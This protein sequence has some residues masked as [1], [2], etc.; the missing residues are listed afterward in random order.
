V[1][2]EATGELMKRFYRTLLDGRRSPAAALAEAQRSM[3]SDPRWGSPYYWA[4]FT[5]NGD[6][7]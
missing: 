2:D 3:G 6:W 7:R 1:D 4:G 5:F